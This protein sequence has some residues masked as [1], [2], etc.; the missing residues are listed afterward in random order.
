MLM[1]HLLK[2]LLAPALLAAVLA[3]A[4]PALAQGPSA[5]DVLTALTGMTLPAKKAS[6]AASAP[7][8]APATVADPALVQQAAR[9]AEKTDAR[10]VAEITARLHRSRVFDDVQVDV[11]A[12]VASLRGSVHTSENRQLAAKLAAAVSGVLAVENHLS[13]AVDF[14][15]RLRET[16][17]QIK[18]RGITLLAA[19]PLLLLGLLVVWLFNWLGRTVSPHVRWLRRQ[20][21]NPYL[22]VLFQRVVHALFVL[23]GLLIALDLLEAT[24]LVTAVLGSAGVVGIVIGFAFRDTAENYLAGM[25]LSLRRPFAPGDHVRIDSHEGRVV[26]LSTRNTILMT[27]DGNELRLPNATVFKAVLLNFSHNPNRRFHFQLGVSYADDLQRAQELGVATIAAMKGVLA[28]P[29]PSASIDVVGDSAVAINYYGWVNQRQTAFGKARSEAIRLVKKALEDA[30][31]DL[32]EPTYRVHLSQMAE[33]APAPAHAPALA[34]ADGRPNPRA[35]SQG[36]ADVS[37]EDELT[38]EIARERA[39]NASEDMLGQKP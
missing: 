30:G 32:P 25:L 14:N 34:S 26:A 24:A 19:A 5:G 39:S 18:D 33:A 8:A 35:I 29:A 4:P 1:K 21:N 12:G 27:L 10:I 11:Q 16:W 9:D 6:A 17:H 20:E 36:Q 3:S 23:A 31:M 22:T 37:A 2:H 7:D 15:T 38:A 28:D 13:L